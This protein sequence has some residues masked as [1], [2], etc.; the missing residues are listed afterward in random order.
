MATTHLADPDLAIDNFPGTDPDQDVETFIQQIERKINFA[1]G[2]APGDCGELANYTFRKK[3]L[4]FSSLRGPTAECTKVTL[5]MLL[6]GGMSEQISSL[7]PQTEETNF[8]IEWKWNI[9]LEEMERK[10]ETLYME[11]TEL[12][13]KG[14][15][16]RWKEMPRQIVVLK[17]LLR[18]CKEDKD[19]S[20]TQ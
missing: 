18:H 20:T 4:F 14:G 3:A 6:L 17:E 2:E 15:Q 12:W 5:P 9:V 11:Y 1:L 10:F 19:T 8:D 7:D 13:I 16:T